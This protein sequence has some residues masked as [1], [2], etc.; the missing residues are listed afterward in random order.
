MHLVL[1]SI[2]RAVVVVD[3]AAVAN[4]ICAAIPAWLRPPHGFIVIW[5]SVQPILNLHSEICNVLRTE[6][7]KSQKATA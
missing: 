7:Q 6:G 2:Y 5:N 4:G 1:I 3:V